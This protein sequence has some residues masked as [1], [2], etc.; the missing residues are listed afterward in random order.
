MGTLWQDIR[1][2]ARTL[3]RSPGYTLVA[4]LTLALGI[5]V[6]AAI[7]SAV[8]AILLRPLPYQHGER[9]VHLRQPQLAPAQ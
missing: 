6:N 2:G 5:G 8:D 4:V 9:I 7:F 1:Y 3:T